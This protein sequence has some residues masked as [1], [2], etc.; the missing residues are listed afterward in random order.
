MAHVVSSQSTFLFLFVCLCVCEARGV[1]V[2]IMLLNFT[3]KMVYG[4]TK[5]TDKTTVK[6]T[7]N[8]H[9]PKTRTNSR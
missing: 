8:T 2:R 5:P 7:V 3:R 4:F 9:G 6:I 1:E